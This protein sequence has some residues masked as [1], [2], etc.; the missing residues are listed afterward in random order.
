MRCG[1]AEAAHAKAAGI[2]QCGIAQSMRDNRDFALRAPLLT[3]VDTTKNTT[4][5]AQASTK[6][7]RTRGTGD[8][9]AGGT[10]PTM[11]S[12]ANDGEVFRGEAMLAGVSRGAGFAVGT[13][14]SGRFGGIGAVGG[15]LL[16]RDG[17]L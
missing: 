10:S 1:G 14:W 13:G 9:I 4:G 11:M 12:E 5:A 17:F 16:F 2:R 8:K 7:Q 15:E 3:A 6:L